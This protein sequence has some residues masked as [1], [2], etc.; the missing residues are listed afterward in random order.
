MLEP[1]AH[2]FLPLDL[3]DGSEDP[4][5]YVFF[6]GVAF[7][8]TAVA[9]EA[10]G[11]ADLLLPDGGLS[12]KTPRLS[13]R[14]SYL[15]NRGLI[16]QPDVFYGPLLGVVFSHRAVTLLGDMRSRIRVHAGGSVRGAASGRGGQS[17]PRRSRSSG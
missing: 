17:D 15:L 12:F 6:A 9:V 2:L 3:S 1:G 7:R 11:I 14:H 13:A 16:G 4:Q 8:P 10:N 5:L